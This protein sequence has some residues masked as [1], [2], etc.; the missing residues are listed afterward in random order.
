MYS[1]RGTLIRSH[2]VPMSLFDL[3][4]CVSVRVCVC[5]GVIGTV[6]QY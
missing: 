5:G 3:I 1:R 2:C 4:V 6:S